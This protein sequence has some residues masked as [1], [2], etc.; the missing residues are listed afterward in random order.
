MIIIQNEYVKDLNGNVNKKSY[1]EGIRKLIVE[2]EDLEFEKPILGKTEALGLQP[3]L[4]K[5]LPA[6]YLLPAITDYSEEISKQSKSTNFRQLMGDLADRILRFDPKFGKIE[7]SINQLTSLLN[8]PPE[9][10]SQTKMERMGLF[11]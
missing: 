4:I 11:L 2:K 9:D 7:E 5:A 3:V 8:A 10:S 6:F 1:E